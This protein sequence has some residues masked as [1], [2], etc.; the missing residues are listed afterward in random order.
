MG[1]VPRDQIERFLLVNDMKKDTNNKTSVC[2]KAV[3]KNATEP[4]KMLGV[5]ALYC[6]KCGKE[7]EDKFNWAEY[8][9]GMK[10]DPQRHI[11][12][13][14]KYFTVKQ[15]TFQSRG[16]V[17]VAMRRHFRAAKAVAEFKTDKI[18][19]AFDYC[20]DKYSNIDWTIETVLKILTST[21]L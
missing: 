21:N 18:R 16:E 20:E 8:L 11:V 10:K 14:A 6:S 19:K 3:V 2:C 13:I 17:G 7:H 4:E 5:P 15:L 1:V 9:A 12:V